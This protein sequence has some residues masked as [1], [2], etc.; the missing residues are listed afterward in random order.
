[1][2]FLFEI[3]TQMVETDTEVSLYDLGLI[4][5]ACIICL[6]LSWAVNFK[7]GHDLGLS[8]WYTP[9]FIVA[10][11]IPIIG[12][13]VTIGWFIWFGFFRGEDGA[14]KY[15]YDGNNFFADE[16]DEYAQ[17]SRNQTASNVRM[18]KIAA[19]TRSPNQGFGRRTFD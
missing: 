1:M 10:S 4:A 11:G 17:P 13:F 19:T 7:R 8:G 2:Y 12:I 9:L 3:T 18:Q 14:N 16:D 6:W 15:D 5:I